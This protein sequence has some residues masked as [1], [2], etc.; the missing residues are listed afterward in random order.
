M[1]KH[2]MMDKSFGIMVMTEN[3]EIY[4]LICRTP[5]HQL[6]RNYCG[7]WTGVKNS[8]HERHHSKHTQIL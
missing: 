5:R 7:K 4:S 2:I 3:E 1:S 6:L 8:K